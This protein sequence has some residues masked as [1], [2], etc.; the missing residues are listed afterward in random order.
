MDN[1][2][3]PFM[4]GLYTNE[5]MFQQDEAQKHTTKHTKE[6]FKELGTTEMDSVL[7]SSDIN[8]IE[9]CWGM[10]S[11]SVCNGGRQLDIVEDLREA[12]I[13]EWKNLAMED[14]K[15]LICSI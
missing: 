14:V 6:Y 2:E 5:M 15:K 13:S 1:S 8:S 12:L 10:L 9:N 7:R 3:A 11:R 4:D